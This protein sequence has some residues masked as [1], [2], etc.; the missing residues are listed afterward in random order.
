MYIG[1]RDRN[2]ESW[3]F[4]YKGS[5]LI[6]LDS[7][8]VIFFRIRENLYRTNLANALIDRNI[9]I[10]GGKIDK[11][12]KIFENAAIHRESCEVFLHEFKRTPEREFSLSMSD[13]VFLYF[14]V[15]ICLSSPKTTKKIDPRLFRGK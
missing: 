15:T 4:A 14:L 3:K 7:S 1:T 11:L 5:D 6:E 12:K 13:I 10:S 2:R 9:P 8:K